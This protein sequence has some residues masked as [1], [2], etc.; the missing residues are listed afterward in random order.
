MI[1]CNNDNNTRA[2]DSVGIILCIII[3]AYYGRVIG[4][5]DKYNNKNNHCNNIIII[6]DGGTS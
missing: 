3:Y 1:I 4:A 6:K 2:S 5:G